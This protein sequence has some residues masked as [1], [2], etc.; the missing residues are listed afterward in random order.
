MIIGIKGKG[1]DCQS[2]STSLAKCVLTLT[3]GYNNFHFVDL[4][5]HVRYSLIEFSVLLPPIEASP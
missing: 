3:K 2:W 5:S 1:D 4:Y